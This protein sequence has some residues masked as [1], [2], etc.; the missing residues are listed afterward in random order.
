MAQVNV[1]NGQY[2]YIA[3]KSVDFWDIFY[4]CVQSLRIHLQSVS[5]F[6]DIVKTK[7]GGKLFLFWPLTLEYIV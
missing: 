5:K 2:I 6:I 1:Q 7:E 3:C 4:I